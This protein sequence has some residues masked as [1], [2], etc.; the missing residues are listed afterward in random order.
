MNICF[1]NTI[2]GWGGGEKWHFENA[3]EAMTQGY[4]VYFILNENSKLLDK[5]KLYPNIKYFALPFSKRSYLNPLL[6]LKLYHFFR[7]EEIEV[8][9]FNSI[10]DM[11]TAS[12]PAYKAKV[13][14][15]VLRY[16]WDH[17]VKRKI[18]TKLA[19]DYF[20][21]DVFANSDWVKQR[22][23]E[24]RLIEESEIDILHNGVKLNEGSIQNFI[25]NNELTLGFGGRLTFEKG[26]EPLL[27]VMENLKGKEVKLILAGTG[28]D[29]QKIQNIITQK[30]LDKSVKLLGFVDDM[31]KFYSKIDIL[32]HLT[33]ADGISNTVIEAMV[34]KKPI[35]AFNVAS[36]P[37]IIEDGVNGFLLELNDLNAVLD[38][39]KKFLTE[40]EKIELLGQSSFKFAREKFD[41][42]TNFKLLKQKYLL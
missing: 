41:F 10:R 23:V 37:E 28:P 30:S 19:F 25:Q 33:Y 13:N 29:K 7:K 22:L 35:V 36:M 40:R 2:Q 38:V 1:M 24:S 8:L 17:K 31:D 20:V 11:N 18:H 4:N 21:T 32:M 12:F 26:I 5:L 6:M 27:E 14:R 34:R 15:R 39:I 9:L 3:I 16:G 42:D